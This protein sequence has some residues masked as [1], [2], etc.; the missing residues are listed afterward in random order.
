VGL[1]DTLAGL[2]IIGKKNLYL[3]DGLVQTPNGEV[4]DAKDAPKDVLTVPSGTL[5]ELDSLDQQSRRWSYNEIVES[6]KRM[7]LF[8]DVA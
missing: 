3:I 8:R 1:A 2:L 7:F 6:N 4:I 5:V